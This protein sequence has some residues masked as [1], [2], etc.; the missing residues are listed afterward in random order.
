MHFGQSD[1]DRIHGRPSRLN[2]E[3]SP[4]L[5]GEE[6]SLNQMEQRWFC[7]TINCFRRCAKLEGFLVDSRVKKLLVIGQVADDCHD[8]SQL[9]EEK[10][11]KLEG[12]SR[13]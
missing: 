6:V 9:F 4:Q 13:R 3:L 2:H 12:L 1:A 5:N 11:F 8:S 10:D 7:L